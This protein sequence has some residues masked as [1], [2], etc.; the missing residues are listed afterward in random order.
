LFGTP[1]KTEAST[2]VGARLPIV[3]SGHGKGFAPTF[4]FEKTYRGFIGESKID[5]FFVKPVATERQRSGEP[6]QFAP[7]FGRT[8]SLINSAL[9]P[10]ISDHCPI[11]LDLP[12]T[13]NSTSN[14][15]SRQV[16]TRCSS[17]RRRGVVT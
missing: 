5:W 2:T 6:F 4:F 7:F 3:I 17:A 15:Q 16:A 13:A 14:N 1:K 12:L 9:A 10:R 11:T 8:L